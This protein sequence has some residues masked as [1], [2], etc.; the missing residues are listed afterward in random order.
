MTKRDFYFKMRELFDNI[1]PIDDFDEEM[2]KE[3]SFADVYA[4]LQEVNT[5]IRQVKQYLENVE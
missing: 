1:D 2:A 3:F 4:S 5:L